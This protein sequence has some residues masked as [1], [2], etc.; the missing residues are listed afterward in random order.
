MIFAHESRDPQALV[1]AFEDHGEFKV[2]PD[3]AGARFARGYDFVNDGEHPNDDHGH[4]THVAGTVAA[5][6]NGFGISGVAPEATIVEI[7]A[8]TGKTLGRLAQV[9]KKAGEPSSRWCSRST[10]SARATSSVQ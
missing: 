7:D 9:A 8:L 10:R 1:P 3:L 5:A 4:G 2:V 6:I